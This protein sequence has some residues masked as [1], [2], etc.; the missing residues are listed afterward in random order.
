M[1]GTRAEYGLLSRTMDAI[2]ESRA[3][4]L[5]VIATG[6]HL[7]PEFGETYREIEGDGFSIDA[8][9]EMLLSGDSPTA[10]A[11]SLGLG[12]IGCADALQQLAPDLVMLLGDRFEALAAAQSAMFLRIPILHVHG[13]ETTEGAMDEA[14]RHSITKMSHLHFVATETYRKRVVQLGEDPRRVF[15]VGAL[16]V[17]NALTMKT[18]NRGELETELEFALG[19]RYFLVTY[20]PATLG[21]IPPAASMQE[22]LNALDSFPDTR[23]VITYPNAD[24]H[25]RQLIPMIESFAAENPE[26]VFIAKSLGQRRY[27]ST[28]QHAKAV[29]GNS[30]S[31]II[32]A[33]SMRVPT[34]NI[35]T[36]Q[37]G[38]VQADSILNCEEER[39]AIE[40]AIVAALEEQ[41]QA[42]VRTCENPYG[43]GGTSSRIIEILNDL[44][45]TNLL[46]KR[47]HDVSYEP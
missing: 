32:E 44:E 40:S 13:G 19:D 35:G 10:I 3:F 18:L 9:V 39:A 12:V 17:E 16:G 8:K 36:R 45:D 7:S 29:I 25:G 38:R 22:L 42:K 21:T 11:K 15:N 4:D 5:Q 41:F 47:F 1:T 24:T 43:Q 31:G 28:M 6:M 27:L 26:R 14:I 20:H 23:I 33:P 37:Q 2:R 34:V 46:V 30:S